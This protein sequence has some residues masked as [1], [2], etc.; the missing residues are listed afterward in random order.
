M[1]NLVKSDALWQAEC[2]ADTMARYEEIMSSPSRKKA[3][4]VAAK[5]KVKEME[6]GLDRYKKAAK[7]K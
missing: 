2:D 1:K 4:M 7:R 3:A 5:R 6:A